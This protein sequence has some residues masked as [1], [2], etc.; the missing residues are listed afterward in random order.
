[1]GN[2]IKCAT[3]NASATRAKRLAKLG[4]ASWWDFKAIQTYR[5]VKTRRSNT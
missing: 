3:Y 4:L 5:E 2:T 1:M